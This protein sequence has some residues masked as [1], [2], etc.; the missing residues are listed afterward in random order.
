MKFNII[1]SYLG[2]ILILGLIPEVASGQEPQSP[3]AEDTKNETAEAEK[4]KESGDAEAD[5]KLLQAN[6]KISEL[7]G[8]LKAEETRHKNEFYGNLL[9][10]MNIPGDT[11]SILLKTKTE[12]SS[13]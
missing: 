11:T 7:E 5:K 4:A 2:I 3:P 12:S 9:V 13:C 8:A 10:T 6:A 1:T